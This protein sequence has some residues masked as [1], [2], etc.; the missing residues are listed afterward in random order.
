VTHIFDFAGQCIHIG[1]DE[2]FL[3]G[4]GVEVAVGAAVSAEWDVEIER[5]GSVEIGHEEVVSNW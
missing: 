5:E 4:V 3:T 2:G 1:R